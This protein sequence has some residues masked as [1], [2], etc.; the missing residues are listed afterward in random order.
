MKKLI[1]IGALIVV[2]FAVLLPFASKTPDGLQ[3][4]TAESGSQQQPVWNGLIAEYSI[5]LGNPYV[6][7][8]A[9]GLLGT[10]IVLAAS[11]ALGSTMTQK[12]Q[13]ETPEPI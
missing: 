1:L 11:Y 7:T 10:G 5:A 13:S 6:S 8:L 3:T 9:A 2:A 12:K 4:L